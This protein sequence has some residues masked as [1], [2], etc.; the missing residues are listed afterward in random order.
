MKFLVTYVE[1]SYIAIFQ[2]DG[3]MDGK[4]KGAG[5]VYKEECDHSTEQ[6]ERL[7]AMAKEMTKK[8]FDSGRYFDEDFEVHEYT[9]K[10]EFNR[11]RI[12]E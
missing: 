9:E 6:R 12:Q 4:I 8:N 3:W 5:L 7:R 2:P 10:T 1:T 11:Q